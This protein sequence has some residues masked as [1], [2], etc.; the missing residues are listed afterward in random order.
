MK[1]TPLWRKAKVKVA[2]H[3][4]QVGFADVY[5]TIFQSNASV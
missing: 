2:E 1:R 5:G 3:V 4:H